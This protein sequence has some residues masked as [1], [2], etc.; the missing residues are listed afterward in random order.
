M[1]DKSNFTTGQAMRRSPKAL[2]AYV[3]FSVFLVLF[4][5]SLIS[6]IKINSMTIMNYDFHCR[7]M[8]LLH[9]TFV[10]LSVKENR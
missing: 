8:E 1:R 6:M 2:A 3:L 7:A 4:R 10:L 9:L 5:I